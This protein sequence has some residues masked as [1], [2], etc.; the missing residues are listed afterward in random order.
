MNPWEYLRYWNLSEKVDSREGSRE[1][2][3]QEM[4]SRWPGPYR[5]ERC[6]SRYVGWGIGYEMV[7]ADAQEEIMFRLRWS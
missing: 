4:Q 3:N 1:W 2:I 6:Q 7:F 5:V